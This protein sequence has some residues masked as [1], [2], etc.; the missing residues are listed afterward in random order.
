MRR[1]AGA[2]RAHGIDD[3][4]RVVFALPSSADLLTAMVATLR[5]GA[6]LVPINP[7]LTG[8]ERAVLFDDAKPSLV[9]DTPDALAALFDGPE[10][11]LS[12]VPRS[13]PMHYTSGTTGRPKGVFSGL[14][15]DDEARALFDEE[16]EL[17]GFAAD[18]RNLVVSPL[19]H[20]APLRYASYTPLQ[21]GEVVIVSGFDAEVVASTI[22]ETNPTTAF[23]V[24]AHL[25]RLFALRQLPSLRNFRPVIH[26]VAPC[27]A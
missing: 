3:G 14:L 20:S 5:S 7:T 27:P 6:V 18:D 21:G 11:E 2:L 1:V 15:D 16:V 25:Q 26:A 10:R 12:P 19:Y 9:I 24:P 17:W 23:V 22:A 8:A 13:R 4:D